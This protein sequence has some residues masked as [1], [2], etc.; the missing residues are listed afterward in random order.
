MSLLQEAQIGRLGSRFS[1]NFRPG[2]QCVYISPL[3]RFYDLPVQFGIG[4]ELDGQFYVLPFASGPNFHHFKMVEE[5]LLTEGLQFTVRDATLGI[6]FGCKIHA[7]FY[8]GDRKASM[9][10]FFY[11][12]LSVRSFRHGR[13]SFA[14][15]CGNYF[16]Y[17]GG[18]SQAV[19]DGDSLSASITSVLDRNCWYYTPERSETARSLFSEGAYTGFLKVS[20]FEAGS[21]NALSIRNGVALKHPFSLDSPQQIM[22]ETLIVAGYQPGIVFKVKQQECTFLY[23]SMFDNID[24]VIEYA[25]VEREYL[26]TKTALFKSTITESSL[27]R[28][29]Q[30]VIACGF[31]NYLVNSWWVQGLEGEDWFIIWEGWCSFHSTLDVEYN[32]AWFALLYWPELLEKQLKLWYQNLSPEGFPSHDLGILLEMNQQVYPHDMP[33]EEACNL[34]LLTYALWKFRNDLTWQ[35]FLPELVGIVRYLLTCDTTGNGYPD[36]GVAN[37][38]DDGEATVQYAS[39]QTYLAVKTLAALTAFLEMA[40]QV[41]IEDNWHQ[42]TER[43]DQMISRIKTTMDEEAWLGDHY[44]VCLHQTSEGLR[45][46]WTGKAL[47]AGELNGWDAYSLYTANGLLWL[48]ATGL[49]PDLNY[50]RIKLDL[51]KALAKSLTP[52]GCTHSSFDRSNLWLS[53]NMWRDQFAAY[54]GI[55]LSKMMELYWNFLEW[56]NTQGRGGCYVDSYGWNWLSYYPRGITAVGILA[57]Q[58]GMKIDAVKQQLVLEPVSWPCRFPLLMLADWDRGIVPWFEGQIDD[59]KLVWLID[60]E[61]PPVWKVMVCGTEVIG[62]D[63]GKNIGLERK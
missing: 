37:T 57:S 44:P 31:Q 49:K 61:L 6:E 8:P 27:G 41:A 18:L 4:L 59:G 39:E 32:N 33:V 40:S 15:I 16:F 52:F 62:G 5:E 26:L 36:R 43:A 48:F 58:L 24:R 28:A 17:L 45:D 23:T 54:L 51:E 7:P 22:S 63:T 13:Q 42:I 55:D 60:G 21:W 20:P 9:A 25:R 10:P 12:D 14:P 53:Q 34:I 2:E 50:A 29:A 56:E 3:G 11:I 1:M 38:V 30:S 19:I 46:V 47:D 35:S